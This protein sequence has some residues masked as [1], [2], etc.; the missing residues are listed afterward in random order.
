VIG[1]RTTVAGRPGFRK[2][3]MAERCDRSL[4]AR[5]RP[6]APHL[7]R[8]YHARVS[9]RSPDPAAF[10]R[11]DAPFARGRTPLYMRVQDS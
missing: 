9:R 10:R 5:R 7:R 1:G 8:G 3:M 11:A 6:H 2:R 4:P